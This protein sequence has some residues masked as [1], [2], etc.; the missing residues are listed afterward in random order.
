MNKETEKQKE[1]EEAIFSI[2]GQL[3]HAKKEGYK[4]S[5]YAS[6][7]YK[8]VGGTITQISHGSVTLRGE[9]EDGIKMTTTMRIQDIKRISVFEGE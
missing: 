4:V 8:G 2:R 3:E 9:T 5:I 6:G 1:K 7:T